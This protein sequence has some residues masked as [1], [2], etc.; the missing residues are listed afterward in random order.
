MMKTMRRQEKS[1]NYKIKEENC[2]SKTTTKKK[3]EKEKGNT[4][5]PHTFALHYEIKIQVKRK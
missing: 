1:M 2:F 5:F 4:K 3:K